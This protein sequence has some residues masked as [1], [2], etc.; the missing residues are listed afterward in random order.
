MKKHHYRL[1]L[2]LA[3][4]FVF[5]IEAWA[6]PQL[7]CSSVTACPCQ[8]VAIAPSWNN[9]SSI[10]YT[11]ITPPVPPATTGTQNVFTGT[12]AISQCPQIATLYTYTLIGCGTYT[13]SPICQTI[14]VALQVQPPA[15]LT[16]TNGPNGVY[17]CPGDNAVFTVQNVNAASYTVY[18][19]CMN[20]NPYI[21]SSNVVQFPVPGQNCNGGYTVI[22]VSGGCT[23]TG[24]TSISV[25]PSPALNIIA[26]QNVCNGAAAITLTSNI[27]PAVAYYWYFNGLPFPGSIQ[28]LQ[29]PQSGGPISVGDNG[30]YSLT[31]FYSAYNNSIQCPKTTVT[32][33]N[34]V[35]TSPVTVNASPSGTV[36]QG[37]NLILNASSPGA[38]F[39]WTGPAFTSSLSSPVIPN[40]SA[41]NSGAY[42]VVASFPSP[43]LTC[44]TTAVLNVNVIPVV[45]PSVSL[46]STACQGTTGIVASATAATASNYIWTG[47]AIVGSASGASFPFPALTPTYSGIYY[48]QAFFGNGLCSTT[49]SAQLNVIPV[50]TVSVIAPPPVCSP[51]NAFLQ[52]YS[53]GANSYY[54]VGPNNF[55]SPGG[56]VTVFY[57]TAAASGV[58]TVTAYFGGGVLSCPKTN[59][60]TLTV[61]TPMTFSLDPWHQ[62]CYNDPLTLV[63]P[64]GATSYTWTSSTGIV[65]GGKDLVFPAI[66]PS[67]AGTY[68]LSITSGGC[69]TTNSTQVTVVS[70]ISFSLV[71]SD[72]TL[73]AGDTTFLEAGVYGG[74]DNYAYAWSPALYLDAINGPKHMAVPF[75]SV[76]YNVI[77]HD[78]ACPTFSLSHPVSINVNQAPKPKF[79]LKKETGCVPLT[80]NF[81]S[82]LSPDS[83]LVTYDFGKGDEGVV[84]GVNAVETW[85]NAGKYNVKVYTVDKKTFCHGVYNYP[86]PIEAYAKPGA[87][88]KWSPE[89]P[90]TFDEITF[91]PSWKYKEIKQYHWELSGGIIPNDT[92]KLPNPDT[93]RALSPVRQYPRLGKYPVMLVSTTDMGCTDT[94]GII[95][96]VMDGLQIFVPNVFT[97]NDDGINDVFI[98]KGIGMKPE[99]F[100]MDI[101]DRAG[102]IVFSTKNIDEPWDGK[103]GGQF[104]KDATYTYK[105]KVVGMNGEGR[106]EFIGHVSLLK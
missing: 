88:V 58:Y 34:V 19:N 102:K 13:G 59:F 74:S 41:V 89:K 46:T 80:I 7:N 78:I 15:P 27:S 67:N 6:Q 106:K 87:D 30:T 16:F 31:A 73:C 25:A 17:Y 29:I 91:T 76:N 1:L 84:Q 97:P 93:T 11:L 54:W 68:T 77:V 63:G 72:R 43:F 57:P 53:P 105:I 71:P 81:E 36:C 8:T 69:K 83:A 4:V 100:S 90:T 92:A 39:Q 45:V 60:L 23:M 3:T 104:G 47:P 62:I 66:L 51:N 49:S 98:A 44:T 95:L 40:A 50:N 56:N 85:L 33:I 61:N 24:V 103:V 94:V 70:P 64:V 48:V 86:Y 82:G 10:S 12:T 18:G 26:P 75:G 21:S 52:A 99:G 5:A 38:N 65:S 35:N 9:V 37:T 79:N 14:T 20:P 28:N 96:E 101:F 42:T 55:S 22:A 2:T 32:Q